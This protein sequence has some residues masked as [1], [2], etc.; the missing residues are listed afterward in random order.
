MSTRRHFEDGGADYARHRPTYPPE[1]A[2]ALA[3]EC[4]ATR[5]A[6][7]VGCGT[8]QLTVL[9][10][11]T[12]DAVT[13]IDPSASQIEAATPAPGVTYLVGAAEKLPVADGMADLVVAAQAAHWFDLPAFYAEARR[14]AA[15]GAVLA[16]VSYGVPEID[17]TVGEAFAQFY[18]S[19][20]HDHFPE[21]RRHVEEGYRSLAFPFDERALPPVAIVRTW[22]WAEM[23]GYIETWSATKRARKAGE[24]AMVEREIARLAAAWGEAEIEVR[25]PVVGRLATLR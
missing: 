3:A 15:P 12:F 9:L 6:V 18:R 16:L 21:G 25:W 4:G 19:P 24:T 7:D 8:G 14:I 5:H 17:G 20:L 23:A 11:A 22:R 2:T 13:G 1:L 10:A